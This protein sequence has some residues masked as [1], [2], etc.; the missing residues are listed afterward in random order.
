MKCPYLSV[1]AGK[2]TCKI[3]GEKGVD[4]EV[5]DFDVRHYCDGNPVNCY[6]FRNSKH[7]KEQSGKILT[8]T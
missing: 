6:Y 3:M 8:T 1:E 4:R 7:T 5:S 2:N